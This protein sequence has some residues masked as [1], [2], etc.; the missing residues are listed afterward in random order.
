MT[1][2]SK[3]VTAVS[4][5]V[6]AVQLS[7]LQNRQL[8]KHMKRFTRQNNRDHQQSRDKVKFMSNARV[9][10]DPLDSITWPSVEDIQTA[11]DQEFQDRPA[12]MTRGEQKFVD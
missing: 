4:K 8:R 1:T 11:Q 10:L 5:N 3:N 12:G 7:N 9:D 6:T 2:V